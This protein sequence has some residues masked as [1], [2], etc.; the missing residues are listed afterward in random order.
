MYDHD[1]PF[2]TSLIILL[3][4]FVLS[5]FY[6]V[7]EEYPKNIIIASVRYCQHKIISLIYI[8]TKCQENMEDKFYWYLKSV[9][10]RFYLQIK[11]M[12]RQNARK[13]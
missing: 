8:D 10:I 3:R 9:K 2:S 4:K 1:I 6:S 5:C 11:L 12:S 7:F 13:R